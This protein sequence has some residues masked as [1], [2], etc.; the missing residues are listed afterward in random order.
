MMPLP[1]LRGLIRL[2]VSAA[3]F[4]CI[5]A[6]AYEA[7]AHGV[8]TRSWRA[9]KT[10]KKETRSKGPPA[11][12]EVE[13]TVTTRSD[14]D[15]TRSAWRALDAQGELIAAQGALFLGADA[16]AA[17]H[18]HLAAGALRGDE[19]SAARKAAKELEDAAGALDQGKARD[20][21]VQQA[22]ND[23]FDASETLGV[24]EK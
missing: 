23:G 11:V 8:G 21:A 6:V 9:T 2:A 7:G 17:H 10:A 5:V 16:I 22:I 19:P 13:W 1:R 15:P 14:I 18:L 20:Q 3:A 24:G 4:T 12:T